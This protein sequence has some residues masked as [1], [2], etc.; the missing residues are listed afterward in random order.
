[1]TTRAESYAAPAVIV[2]SALLVAGNWYLQPGRAGAWIVTGAVLAVMTGA[3]RVRRRDG[4]PQ[5][6]GDADIRRGVVFAGVMLALSLGGT[7]AG[8]AGLIG[9][10][11]LPRRTLMAMSG[12]LLA[13][14]GNGMPKTLTPL[15]SLQCDPRVAQAF[16]RFAG[17]VWV[18]AG[19]AVAVEWIFVPLD[20]AT[21]VS[22]PTLL[23]AVT[24]TIAWR[25]RLLVRSH[26]PDVSR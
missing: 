18:L 26:Q 2:L 14:F 19:L 12:V 7:L 8:A 17:W 5:R 13:Y 1:M 22:I 3:L 6:D 20:V 9:R 15:S 25:V 11:E 23:A 16:R 10:D 21:S 24:V 4:A